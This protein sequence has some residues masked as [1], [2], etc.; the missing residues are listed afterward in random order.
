MSRTRRRRTTRHLL[1]TIRSPERRNRRRP[2]SSHPAGWIS[3]R[4]LPF[5]VAQ[6]DVSPIPTTSSPS[7]QVMMASTTSLLSAPARSRG[8]SGPTT[9]SYTR[10]CRIQWPALLLTLLCFVCQAI[11]LSPDPPQPVETLELD[12]RT[13][14]FEEGSWVMLSREEQEMRKLGKRSASSTTS[15]PPITTTFEI[16]V[17]TVTEK[18]TTS[19]ASASPLPSPL[20]S[21]LSSNFSGTN[22]NKPC[23]K[24]INSF[25]TDP[26]FK[27]C[28]PFSLLLQVH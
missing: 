16:A 3:S 19:T 20:D 7:S 14:H 21:S 1:P 18:T 26:T 22:G 10:N 6:S 25:L 8:F 24:F 9:V 5:P 15:A 12:T 28:Y 27:Q 13:P 11:A 4:S 23:P 2:Q 17:S